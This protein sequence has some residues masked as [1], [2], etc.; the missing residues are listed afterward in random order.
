MKLPD[1]VNTQLGEPEEI[2]QISPHIFGLEKNIEKCKEQIIKGSK[3]I[4]II[5]GLSGSGKDTVMEKIIERGN[6]Y[7]RVKTCTTR[8]IRP[9]ES[10]T[11][12]PYVRID[13][14]QLHE[15]LIDGTA[16]ECV[17][18]AGNYYCTSKF[19]IERVLDEGKIPILRVDPQGSIF[20]LSAKE[21]GHKFLKDFNFTYIFIVPTSFE[22]LRQ[23]LVLRGSS[24]TLIDE[25]IKQSQKDLTFIDHAHYIVVNEFGNLDTVI[26]EVLD[27]L[28]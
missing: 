1:F 2:V 10:K 8:S 16:L 21:T 12:D 25:R 20:F 18:Y 27:I 15:M 19:E 11:D 28:R 7:K 4:L 17:E 13:S 6:N 26:G 22:D 9:E 24:Q 14:D 3:N 5:S 23:R